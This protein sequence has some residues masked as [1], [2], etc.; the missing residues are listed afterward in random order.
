[1]LQTHVDNSLFIFWEIMLNHQ[2]LETA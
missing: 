2:M 1:M